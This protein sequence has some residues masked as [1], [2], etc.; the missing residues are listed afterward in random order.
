VLDREPKDIDIFVPN[1]A[2]DWNALR[3]SPMLGAAEYMERTEVEGIFDIPGFE[4]PVQVIELCPGLSPMERVIA[5]DF[6]ICQ[7]Y[8]TGTGWGATEAFFRDRDNRTFTLTHCED[9]KEFDRSMR[10]WNRL[11]DKFPGF[12]LVIQEEFLQY[13]QQELELA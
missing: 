9:R 13:H 7:V 6:G 10:R 2:W 12:S 8:S 5:H 3:A 11:K 1:G 4:L